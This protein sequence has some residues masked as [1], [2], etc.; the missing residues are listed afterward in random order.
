ME[1]L[2]R[3]ISWM[4]IANYVIIKI[5]ARTEAVVKS[6]KKDATNRKTK[7]EN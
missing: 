2:S 7:Q 4:I 1:R 5:R 3:D 6:V